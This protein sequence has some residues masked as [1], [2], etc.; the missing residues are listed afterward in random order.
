METKLTIDSISE[1]EAVAATDAGENFVFPAKFLPDGAK[2]GDILII[3]VK[4]EAQAKKDKE[5]TA[6]DILNELLDV[7][8]DGGQKK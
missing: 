4:T 7:S 5:K 6:K 2:K 8:D 1:T 3:D